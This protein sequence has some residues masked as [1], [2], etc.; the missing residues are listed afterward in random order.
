MDEKQ[1]QLILILQQK[2]KELSRL[3][4]KSDFDSNTICLIKQKLGPFPRALEM[5]ELKETEKIS[6]KEKSKRKRERINKTQKLNK[7]RESGE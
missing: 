4:K 5:A 3:P 2:A 1:Q 7:N 6:A